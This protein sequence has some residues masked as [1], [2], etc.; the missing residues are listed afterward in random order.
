MKVII[1]MALEQPKQNAIV[2]KTLFSSS[3]SNIPSIEHILPSALG[4]PPHA[5][6]CRALAQTDCL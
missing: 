2:T 4:P 5:Q 6:T 1:K 3:D